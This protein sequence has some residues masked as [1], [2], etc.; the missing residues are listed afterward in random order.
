MDGLGGEEGVRGGGREPRC[1]ST[2]STP[3]A[4]SLRRHRL[5]GEQAAELKVLDHRKLL[6][7][8]CLVHADEALVDLGPGGHGTD[9][10]ELVGV[11]SKRACLHLC[12][13]EDALQ[14]HEVL[15]VFIYHLLINKVPRFQ[16]WMVYQLGT[17]PYERQELEVIQTPHTLAA[18]R[19]HPVGL[20]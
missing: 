6:Q 10:P 3:P 2:A 7:A 5:D 12:N 11:L 4:V 1:A 16:T 8:L 18:S 15:M 9:V 14:E 17:A 20:L 13:E 19:F